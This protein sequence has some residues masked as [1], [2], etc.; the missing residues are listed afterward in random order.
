M[1]APE[2]TQ[3][4]ALEEITAEARQRMADPGYRAEVDRQLAAFREDF[5]GLGGDQLTADVALG[6]LAGAIAM[7][8]ALHT[9]TAGQSLPCLGAH[10]GHVLDPGVA[11]LDEMRGP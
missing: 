5:A 1:P 6:Y 8:L 9:H 10:V 4:E 3:A 2:P 7:L 11:L